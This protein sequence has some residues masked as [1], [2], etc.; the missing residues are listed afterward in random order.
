MAQKM[1]KKMYV[2]EVVVWMSGGMMMPCFY[3]ISH[4]PTVEQGEFEL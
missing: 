1:A 4:R 3:L 2:P